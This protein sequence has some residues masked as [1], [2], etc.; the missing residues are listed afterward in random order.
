MLELRHM[1][2]PAHTRDTIHTLHRAHDNRIFVHPVDERISGTKV[3]VDGQERLVR[4]VQRVT[5]TSTGEL[6]VVTLKPLPKQ[7]EKQHA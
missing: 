5:Y 3:L 1:E 2:L 7:K 4:S 6:L